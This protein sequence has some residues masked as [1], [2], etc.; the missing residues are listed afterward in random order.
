MRDFSAESRDFPVTNRAI[1]A[2]AVPMSLA[3]MTTPFLGVV[4]TAVVGRMGEAALIGGL[5]VGAVVIDFV[6]SCFNFLRSG[7]TGLVAQAMGHDDEAEEQAAFLRAAAVALAAG[8]V[9]ALAA[10]LVA[11]AGRAFMQADPAVSAAM[12]VYVRIRMLGAPLILLNYA[13]LGYVLGRG[14][15]RT[16]LGIQ[17]ALNGAN[18]VLSL[19]LGLWMGWGVAGVAWATI[20]GEALAAIVGLA[21]VKR[22]FARARARPS[23][24]L[25]RDPA[26]FRRMMAM[27]GDIMARSF[28]LLCVYLLF[29]RQGAQ[30]GPEVL[31]ANALLMNLFVLLT[32]FMDGFAMAAEQMGGRA[33]GAGL[34]RTFLRAVRLTTLWSA[35]MGLVSAGCILLSGDLLVSGMTD[36]PQVRALAHEHLLWAA[37]AGFSGFL[38][39][40]M[41][42]V[43]IG[44]SWSRDMRNR[45]IL[46]VGIFVA[47]LWI[48]I[49]LFGNH[50]LWAALHVFFVA[51]GL[52][53]FARLPRRMREGFP[54]SA[55]GSLAV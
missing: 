29:A 46:S 54:A 32:F 2:I 30:F 3:Y 51:R 23:R 35:A 7:T 10:P 34:R 16:G 1:L 24:A 17:L 42:A 9:L 13:I 48:L 45:M 26:A 55:P 6:F 44:A 22:R 50:G 20:G 40:Q 25:L 19:A 8:V 31:A 39:F 15:G 18:L 21:L 52:T 43:F 14:E 11:W 37:F 36:L 53:L 28:A 33:Y 27:N 41:D 38:A 4:N 49:P 47:A 12:E 5:A